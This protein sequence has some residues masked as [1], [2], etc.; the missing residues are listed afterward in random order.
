MSVGV[1]EEGHFTSMY[2][3]VS[4]LIIYTEKE[5]SLAQMSAKKGIKKYDMHA[6]QSVLKQFTQFDENKVTASLDPYIN[7]SNNREKRR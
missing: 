7:T 5:V 4:D 3:R 6:I 1:E 2:K